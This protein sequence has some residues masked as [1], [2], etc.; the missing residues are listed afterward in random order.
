MLR[1]EAERKV[2][3]PTRRRQEV[4]AS[5]QQDRHR[6]PSVDVV[7]GVEGER[8]EKEEEEGEGAER[9]TLHPHVDAEKLPEGQPRLHQER[10][11]AE[12]DQVQ[13]RGQGRQVEEL[14]EILNCSGHLF[15]KKYA[16]TDFFLNFCSDWIIFPV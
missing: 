16:K 2:E 13:R 9:G 15:L 1:V 4:E 10:G 7:V 5:E 12:D 6:G 8:E 14:S 11:F 3:S